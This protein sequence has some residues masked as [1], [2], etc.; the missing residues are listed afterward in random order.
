M[1]PVAV[2]LQWGLRLFGVFWI[3]GS[4]L[5]LQAA[6]QSTFLD[7]AL[8]QMTSD[9]SD[10]LLTY[11][12]WLSSGLTLMSGLGLA[13]ASRWAL[14]PLSLSLVTQMMYFTIQDR[15]RQRAR[16]PEAR[17][18]ATVSRASWNAF[19]V[20]WVVAGL[21]LVCTTLGIFS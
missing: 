9:K 6:R 21:A 20:T 1:H 14:V 4:F 10:R 7:A 19:K 18:D 17:S 16:T 11:H 5:T 12:L 13:L 8:E 2:I 15:R 3:I